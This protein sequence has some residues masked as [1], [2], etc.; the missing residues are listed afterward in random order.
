MPSSRTAPLETNQ[1]VWKAAMP[2][3]NSAS[4]ADGSLTSW[5]KAFDRADFGDFDLH[6]HDLR[7]TAVTRLA[8]IGCTVP[9]I[10][11]ITGHSLKDMEVIL[12]ANYLGGQA[13]L[14]DQAI[15]KVVAAFS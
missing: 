11:A 7:G 15:V 6:F 10:A 12:E 5:G 4:P 2:A 9:Q 3:V 8:L 1:S 14:A 13:E